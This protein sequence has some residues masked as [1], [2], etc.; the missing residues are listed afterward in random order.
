MSALDARWPLPAGSRPVPAALE[1]LRVRLHAMAAEALRRKD[2]A[3][4]VGPCAGDEWCADV[5]TDDGRIR[6]ACRAKSPEDAAQLVV[7]VLT[8]S[9]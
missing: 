9:T 2:F 6:V 3:A 7:A 4:W 5:E 8:R 1:G